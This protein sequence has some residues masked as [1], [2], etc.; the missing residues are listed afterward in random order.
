MTANVQIG[1]PLRQKM[2]AHTNAR[3]V[4]ISAHMQAAPPIIGQLILIRQ[5]YSTA[6]KETYEYARIATEGA[7]S[8]DRDG[9]LVPLAAIMLL[10]SP[11]SAFLT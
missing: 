5:L 4:C 10:F 11:N 9:G 1:N 8:T 3:S 2:T 6:A 7:Q